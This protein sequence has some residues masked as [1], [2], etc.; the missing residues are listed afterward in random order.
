MRIAEWYPNEYNIAFLK[1]FRDLYG[2]K[3]FIRLSKNVPWENE[4]FVKHFVKWPDN[5]EELITNSNK[6]WRLF[7]DFGTLEGKIIGEREG[8]IHG[9]NV[10]DDPVFCEFLTYYFEG[11]VEKI[12]RSKVTVSHD[13]CV[14][15]GSDVERWTIKW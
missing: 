14:F 5:P 1:V 13:E 15:K 2:E 11:L 3:A 6:L 10:S 8:V 9:K 7:Y 4:G 12:A